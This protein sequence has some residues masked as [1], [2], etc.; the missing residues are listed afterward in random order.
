MSRWG[1][2]GLIDVLIKKKREESQVSYEQYC[3][4]AGEPVTNK[5]PGADTALPCCPPPGPDPGRRQCIG[6][7][8]NNCPE[9]QSGDRKPGHMHTTPTCLHEADIANGSQGPSRTSCNTA[10]HKAHFPWHVRSTLFDNPK[11]QY[12]RSKPWGLEI[13]FHQ[14]GTTW[15]REKQQREDTMPASE[16]IVG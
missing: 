3:D 11:S 7:A 1:R 13:T 8:L 6:A 4:A 14:A 12:A 16:P 2:S 15:P 10:L 5:K 9:P